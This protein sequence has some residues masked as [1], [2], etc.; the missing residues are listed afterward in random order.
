MTRWLNSQMHDEL[1]ALWNKYDPIGVY[2]FDDEEGDWPNDEY[3]GYHGIT[4]KLL[5]GKADNYKFLKQ[6]KHI[7]TV[8][9]GIIWNE[10]LKAHTNTF[11]KDLSNWF[12]KGEHWT[13]Q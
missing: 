6:L 5:K 10:Q 12:A 4:L 11:I 3:D 13:K 8:N 9:M 7:V 2:H 1:Q